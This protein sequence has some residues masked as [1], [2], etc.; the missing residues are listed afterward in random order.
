MEEFFVILIFSLIGAAFIM[1]AMFISRRLAPISFYPQKFIPYEC[2]EIPKGKAWISYNLRFFTMLFVFILFEVDF[3]LLFPWAYTLKIF[4][5]IAVI[6]GLLFVGLLILPYI[7]LLRN[8][9]LDW[10]K[11]KVVGFKTNEGLK[12]GR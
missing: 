8:G 4:G 6:E 10:I 7:Y 2:G 9:D 11:P 3:L 12:V 1:V 5:L